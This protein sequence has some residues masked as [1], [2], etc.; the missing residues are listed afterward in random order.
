MDRPIQLS[1]KL[2]CCQVKIL[3]QQRLL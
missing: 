2:L 3:K 1:A